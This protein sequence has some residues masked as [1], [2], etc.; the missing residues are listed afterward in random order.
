M[1]R[2][3]RLI[4]AVIALQIPIY[5]LTK[6]G[7]AIVII[8]NAC[9][10]TVQFSK[11]RLQMT[12][13][14][15]QVM[16]LSTKKSNRGLCQASVSASQHHCITAPQLS[17][18]DQLAPRSQLVQRASVLQDMRS[19]VAHT[20]DHQWALKLPPAIIGSKSK[21]AW[22]VGKRQWRQSQIPVTLPP[23]VSI[24]RKIKQARISSLRAL[25]LP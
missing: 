13:T 14:W 20:Q 1:G 4:S 2:H 6:R 22:L 17:L 21:V 3:L 11:L 19:T 10:A 18:C 23:W 25:S 8:T 9:P 15:A 16:I 7:M 12:S 24:R 5:C